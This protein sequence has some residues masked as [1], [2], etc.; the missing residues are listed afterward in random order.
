M[1]LFLRLSQEH[2]T[3]PPAEVKAVIEA[4]NIKAN[5]KLVAQG[6]ITIDI[7]PEMDFE[8]VYQ[9]LIKR[10]G[11][12]HEISHLIKESTINELEK[13]F[14]SINW[15]N[16]IDTNFAI[17]LKRINDTGC[18][19]QEISL[20][21][22]YQGNMDYKTAEAQA[23][24]RRLGHLTLEKYSNIKV[25]LNNPQTYIHILIES[26]NAYIG[27]KKFKM[28]KKYFQKMKAHKRPFF[29]PGS[30]DPKLA[31]C[32]VNLTRVKEGD[33]VLDPFCGTGGI[34]IEA[35][36]VGAKVLGS[37]IDKKMVFGTQKNLRFAGINE[38]DIEH[39]DARTIVL[40]EKVNAVVTDP[41]YGISSSTLGNSS[42][43]V[44][45]QFLTSICNLLADDGLLCMASPHYLNIEPFLNESGLELQE[46]YEIRMHKS[47]TRV[48]SLIHKK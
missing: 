44:F 41:P 27:I 46:K 34:L 7:N 10:L 47:L 33:T 22:A 24:E 48:I 32:M 6:L 2:Y 40:D 3:L 4:E 11:Y 20:E 13:D 36:K 1:K 21:N 25:K 15:E 37:D 14:L 19:Y 8:E 39:A 5:V 29:Y 26:D 17:R 42:G 35:G 30:M 18:K 38:F 43:E 23:I 12:T 31:R 9:I 16:Y 28:D 45:K